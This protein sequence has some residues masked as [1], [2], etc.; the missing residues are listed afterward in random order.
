MIIF[1]I[2]CNLSILNINTGTMKMIKT[3]GEYKS[4]VTTVLKHY[5]CKYNMLYKYRKWCKYIII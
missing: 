5:F 1:S 2:L 3:K 4:Q